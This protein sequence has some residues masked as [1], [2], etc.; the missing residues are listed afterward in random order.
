M[1]ALVDTIVLPFKGQLANRITRFS[2][3]PLNDGDFIRASGDVA[4]G[5]L[6]IYTAPAGYRFYLYND[7]FQHTSIGGGGSATMYIIPS[8]GATT[9]MYQSNH[10][11][12]NMVSDNSNARFAPNI[13]EAGDAVRIFGQAN[14]QV[15][16]SIEGYLEKIS[17]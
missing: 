10:S 17:N 15:Y 8:A 1:P 14:Q 7:S 4:N 11:A 5:T 12:G 6:T 13:L 3:G 9:Y 16:A 2:V